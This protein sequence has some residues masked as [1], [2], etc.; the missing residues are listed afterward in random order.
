MP[1]LG[2]PQPNNV[3]QNR[4][5]YTP[6]EILE[7]QKDGHWGGSLELI[8]ESTCSGNTTIEFTAI[9]EN[10]YDTHFI[11]FIGLESGSDM[12]NEIRVSNDGGTSYESTNYDR[13]VQYMS[14]TTGGAFGENRSDGTD[15]F[16][17]LG[18]ATAG[19]PVNNNAYLH[20]LGNADLY[21]HLTARSTVGDQWVY[22]GSQMYLVAETINALQILN[23][24]GASWT[25]GKVRL[26]GIKQ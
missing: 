3:K 5:L 1:Y 13:S 8:A 16:T 24:A 18:F 26:F 23:S 4:G 20:N 17:I 15:R 9:K 10:V 7:L 11:E 21:T 12:Y 2:A 25:A 22:F 6:G 14:A 19:T